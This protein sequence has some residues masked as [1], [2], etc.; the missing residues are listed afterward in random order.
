[1]ESRSEKKIKSRFDLPHAVS[2]KG[3]ILFLFCLLFPMFSAMPQEKRLLSGDIVFRHG[4]GFWSEFIRKNT[5]RDKRFSHAGIIW[6]EC[7]K[8]WVIHAEGDDFSGQ[9]QVEKVPLAD[10]VRTAKKVGFFRLKLS[11]KER[12][13]FAVNALAMLN[14]EFDWKFDKN[15]HR[16]VYCTELLYVALQ[17]TK[18]GWLI[19]PDSPVIPVSLFSAPEIAEELTVKIPVSSRHTP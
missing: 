18:P 14:V 1:M 4:S 15:D 5:P 9:G 16:K 13:D 6:R 7:G 8:I 11:A 12:S 17:K 3:R 19:L 10:F 2:K